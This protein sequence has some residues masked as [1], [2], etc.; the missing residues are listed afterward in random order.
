MFRNGGLGSKGKNKFVEPGRQRN[1]RSDTI[2]RRRRL[3]LEGLESRQLLS[4][5]VV[6][7]TSDS[8][9]GSLRQA[10]LSVNAD[11]VGGVP[12]PDVIDF[13]IPAS[14]AADLDVPVPGFDP[15]T[16]TWRITPQTP[17]PAITNTVWIDGYSEADFGVPFRYPSQV[18]LAVQSLTVLGSP[19]GGTFTL[20]TL[21]PLPT[22]TTGPIPY[23]A[24]AGTVQAALEAIIG[25]GNVT[26]A[27]GP[28][29]DSPMTITFGGAYARRILLPLQ[30]TS[31]LTGGTNPGLSIQT[32]SIGGTPIGDPINIVSVPNT[33]DAKDGNNAR[34]RVIVDGH[35]TGG[36][37]GFVLDESH[38][39]LRGLIITGFGSGVSVP[40]QDLSGNPVVGNFI[41]GN[42]IGDYFV[43]PVDTATGTPL[44][45]P[46]EVGFTS[47]QG[48]AE[49]GVILF[50]SN[51]TVGGSN[52]QENNVI[53]GNGQQ[54][55][56]IEPGA[57][58]NQ[59]L[60]NQVG[61]A[62]PSDN[63]LYSQDGNGAEG[64]LIMSSGTLANPP[65]IVYSS[66]NF[67]G[68]ATGGNLISA[69]AGAGVRLVGVG[70]NRNLVQGN[71][72]GTGPGGGYRFGT[73]DPGNLGDGVR[74]EDGSQNLV[75]GASPTL[76]NTIAS[77]LGAGVYITG[78][79][80]TN[81]VANNMI[82]V[83][84]TGTQILGNSADGVAVY[85][86]QNTIGPGNVISQNLRG[87][88]IY[89]QGASPSGTAGGILVE[90]NLIGTDASG[91]QGFGNALEGVRIDQSASNTIQGDASGSQVISGNQVG[92][93]IIGSQS[94]QNILEG[95]L[96][97][98]DVTGLGDLGNKHEG[99]LLRAAMNNT[100]GGSLAPSRNLISANH[101][102]IRF[103]GVGTT[104]NAVEGNYIGPDLSGTY[105]LGNE[106]DGVIFSN[107]A[108]Q[109]TVG[110]A[111]AGL[112][113]TIAFQV[114]AGVLVESGTGDSILSNTIFGNGRLG[115]DLVAPGSADPPSGV[116]PNAPGIRVGPNNLQNYPVL[117]TV[118][119]NGTTTHI[120]GSLNSLPGTT[121][122]IQFFTNPTA[123]PSG[124]G[125]G[126]SGFGSTEVT[127][128]GSGNASIDLQ[129][130]EFFPSGA[131]LSATAT[132]LT[133][134]DTS[135]FAGDIPQSPAFQFSSALYMTSESSGTAV[136]TVARDGAGAAASVTCATVAGGTAVPGSD[137]VPVTATLNF[138]PG[139]STQTFSVQILDPHLVGGFR[140]V[141]LALSNPN[142][143]LSNA[144]D[145]QPTAVLRII[146]NDAGSSGSFVVTNTNDSGPG[147]LRQAITSADAAINPG[148]I[149]FDIPAATDSLLRFP[150][151][152]F[153]PV[154]QTWTIQVKSPLP[155]IT[156]T[157]AID[158][159]T[160][161]NSGVPFRY[162]SQVSSAV[163]TVDLT[164]VLTG[165]TF[166]LSTSPPLPVGTT[167]PIA[168]D[169]TPIQ[170]QA[171]LLGIQGMA[172]NVVVTGAPGA[173][174]ITFQGA[175]AEKAIPDLIGNP[176][177][178]VG[179]FPGMQVAT[180]VPGGLPI[181]NPTMIFSV[182]NTV[183]ARNGNNAQVRVI[184]DG[185]QTGGGTGLM[186]AASHCL[187]SGL[188]IDGFGIGV[189]VP[190]LADLGNVIQGNS[191]GNYL[192]YPVDPGTGTPV[193]G[194]GSVEL[195]GA[196]NE[197]EGVYLNSNNTT[198]GGT[199]P[200]ENNVIAG[201]L[202]QGIWID[203]A[204]TGNVIEGNQ[205]GM[206]GPS[207]NGRYFQVGNG[208]DGVLVQ[209]SSSAIGGSGASTA[210]VISGNGS[211]GIHILGS[212]ATR[213]IVGANLIG[214]APGG[215]YL[216]GTGDPGNGGSGILIENSPGNVIGG[217]DATWSNAISSN[218]GA[219]VLITG[220]RATGNSVLNNLIGL[221]AGG[222]SKKG[223]L[224]DGVAVFSPQ[225]T[226]GPGNVISGNLRGV[227][228]SGSA[229]SETLV[230]DN[231]I[232]TDITG[233]LDLGNAAEGVLISSATDAVIKGGARGS[234]VISGNHR[235]IVI[236]GT[237]STRNLVQGNLIGTDKTG[238]YPIP[239]A[240]EGVA[241]E[242]AQGNTVG[243]TTAATLNLISA[244]HWGVRIDGSAASNNL[245]EGNL[246]GTDIT[247]KAALGN[248]VNGV[249]ESHS[250]SANTIGGTASGA[251]NT[252]AF[253]VLAGVSIASGTGDPIL[254]NS[255]F[256]N[257]KLGIDLV[258]PGDPA[259]GVTPDAPGVRSGPNDLQNYPTL[260]SAIGGGPQSSIQGT[261]N[262]LPRTPFL[263]QF[264]TNQVP[265]PSGF[266]QGMTPIGST[267]VTTD[268]SGDASFPF[269]PQ[270]N[271]PGNAWVT[272]T[273]TNT[274]TGDTS[275][276]S[277]AISAQPVS[278]QFL[279][280]SATVGATAGTALVHVERVGNPSAIV[281]VNYATG[282]GTAVAGK[283]YTAAIGTLTFQVGETDKTFSVTVLPNPAQTASSVTVNLALSGPTGGA[284]LGS[285][286]TAVLT[287]ND[288]L[289]PILQ[290]QSSAYTA[291]ASST[292]PI[293]TVTR[294][295]GRTRHDRAGQLRHGG[296]LGG[297]G[298]R[299]HT[300]LRHTY[301]P[302]QPDR[303]DLHGADSP[304]GG[305]CDKQ[306][307]WTGSRQSRRRRKAGSAQLCDS[308][309]RVRAIVKS[310]WSTRWPASPGYR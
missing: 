52:P 256:S 177:G 30:W 251:G 92:V 173:Y 307:G 106:V 242:G 149:V 50:S 51:T 243:G 146:D 112:R 297:R 38:S 126:Q 140:T 74:I 184:L 303:G 49:Q 147:S 42:F 45:S 110:G 122:L 169:A 202:E 218:S 214:L 7:N 246:I 31:N 86:P 32:V 144:I 1:S 231:L 172:G 33:V 175:F 274:L 89:G 94:A 10:I 290:F 105:R 108:S 61:I 22:G 119:S 161:A 148:T 185:S 230:D 245:V 104:G 223:N 160:Q 168:F 109:N 287:I 138:A 295:G 90:G 67:V 54:G 217:P 170:V 68:S 59:I 196:G 283:D 157:V 186:L 152:G 266:G 293:V 93:A 128:D 88:G 70:A 222:A 269:T 56:L 197:L 258:A 82:G 2:S 77:N 155:P 263:I 12:S 132:N 207:S 24:N 265:D 14:T 21:A 219:G 72:I 79:A 272:A 286:S 84:A 37:T 107:G 225:N 87:I 27:G 125:Q 220:A 58:G 124:H 153:D 296:R 43:Y 226:I 9:P 193:P 292:S 127:T 117:T 229:A 121:F 254:S 208:A 75:G 163:Q 252:I 134:G 99:V 232:G 299:L 244:N 19:T 141:N 137:Y 26:V 224:Q 18:S 187:L 199:N 16:Q 249:I 40:A 281:S 285:I 238:L 36:S 98:S 284:T 234:Q 309:H 103:D 276:F 205:I 165:G 85:S 139:V 282:D 268:Q 66:S 145:F 300:G 215:G 101:W 130:A 13:Q 294:G 233:A 195:A 156:Q 46:G 60:G 176:N 221:T 129:L 209:G 29:P 253:N 135:E 34:A 250:A 248:E 241:I 136:I 201:N 100:I 39:L 15:G 57:S 305:W 78:V 53:C 235:G 166:T 255:I 236:T 270:T 275:E 180:L 181:G 41:Q 271:L 64:V 210:N 211:D 192:L 35:L 162:P 8:G 190:S 133:T 213:T 277:H 188:I 257:G 204:A 182:P 63:G 158:G 123:D 28:A 114:M 118:T 206:I 3:C 80:T 95:N 73:G 62:G 194:P 304:G 273:A 120:V 111:V 25:A 76:G 178:L 302:A 259:S 189:S 203:A 91:L 116:T 69:N 288:N 151:P 55:I 237:A 308:D 200:Q 113:N 191:I 17:L 291:Y 102:G 83:T 298:R 96:I 174:T 289:P 280:A 262:S 183:A 279:T 306:D 71:Y 6:N 115:I 4:T 301:V 11:R 131:F 228:I 97:G 310:L 278:V 261:L 65:G 264:F 20:S 267:M 159:Y 216:L 164:G 171:A 5:Y 247:G 179:A 240:Q 212:L 23:N 150:V 44:P 47:G 239:N 143:A 167:G 81:T 142:P 198:V 48:N 227:E 154:T 260:T